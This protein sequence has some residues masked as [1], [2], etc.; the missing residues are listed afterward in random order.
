MSR[1]VFPFDSGS[2]AD[3]GLI[4]RPI[5]QV[6]FYSQK[7]KKLINISMLIDTGADYTLLP[8]STAQ[9]LGIDLKRDCS[10]FSTFGVGG[11]EKVYILKNKIEIIIGKIKIKIPLGFLER[12]N[13]PPLLGRF[14]CLES[15]ELT[16]SK[17][18]TT[19]NDF[20]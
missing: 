10:V 12:D 6:Q 19:F 2:R 7:Y 4:R 8:R 14:Q 17:F 15:L 1:I 9:A 5:A 13:I 11:K 20:K 3:L 16:F 18:T